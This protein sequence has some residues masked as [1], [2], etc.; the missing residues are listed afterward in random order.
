MGAIKYIAHGAAL[1]LLALPTAAEA[2]RATEPLVFTPDGA[3]AADYAEDSC[4]L[5]RTF[6][7]GD[8]SAIFELR[9]F[10]PSS[11][12][13]IMVLSSTLTPGRAS[14]RVRFLPD[15]EDFQP[16]ALLLLGGR[17]LRGFMF[18][19]SL[20]G[21]LSTTPGSDWTNAEQEAREREIIGFSVH[22]MFDR[23]IVLQTGSL[24]VPMNA[25]RACLDELL[26]HWGLDPEQQ[27]NLSQPATLVNAMSWGQAV[28]E[29]LSAGM[30]RSGRNEALNIR[31]MVDADGRPTSCSV[32]LPTAHQSFD[33]AACDISMRRA[34]FKPALDAAG[35]PVASYH[36][37]F[38]IV[39]I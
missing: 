19:G 20:N 25:M 4:A 9:Q 30:V 34:R 18:Y 13:R 35:N 2:Q 26:T 22:A 14:P 28:Q 11:A 21:P 23:E 37:S 38:F 7:A 12:L 6:A 3:W 36:T 31:L 17:D 1:A 33:E 16:G 8:Q 10:S 32:Q 15:E 29:S 39:S 5:R 27:Y 24:L